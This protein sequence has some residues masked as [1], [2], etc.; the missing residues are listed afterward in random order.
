M[1]VKISHIIL[2]YKFKHITQVLSGLDCAAVGHAGTAQA[3]GERGQF[4]DLIGVYSFALKPEEHQ[5][6]WNM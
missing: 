6:T 1:S 3:P 4:D 5:P 2:K